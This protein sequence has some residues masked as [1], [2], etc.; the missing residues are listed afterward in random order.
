MDKLSGT[1]ECHDLKIRRLFFANDLVLL[2]FS[3]SGLQHALNGFAPLIRLKMG[4]IE[5]DKTLGALHTVDNLP[6]HTY[7]YESL[8][9]TERVR[10]QMQ[11]SEM[12]FLPKIK[13]LRCLTNF[14]TLRFEN[15]STSSRYFSGSKNLSLGDLTMLTKFLRNGFPKKL[16]LLKLMRI[17]QLDDHEQ[18]G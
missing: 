17:G 1:N 9:M 8:V 18:D 6:V 5:K 12:R 13:E 3:E 14:V 16:E 4:A 7:L 15:L 2:A 10:S 11:A